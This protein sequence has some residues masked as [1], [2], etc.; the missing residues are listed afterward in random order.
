MANNEI[1]Y[2]KSFLGKSLPFPKTDKT[3]CTP[4]KNGTGYEIKYTHFSIFL[5][6]DRRL[7]Y[8]C[9]V[10]IKGEAYNAP[11][12]KGNEPWDYSD[13]VVP[14]YQIDNDFYGHD[15][16][17]FDRG[18]IVRRVD[19]CWGDFS[20]QAEQDTFHWVNC[21]P[22]HKKL[23][24]KG[25]IWYQL[26]QHVIE[27][28]VKNKLANVS[29]FAGP[30]LD[31]ADLPFKKKY[32]NSLVKVPISF[33]KVIVWKKADGNLY[34]VGFMM[35]QWE[36]IKDKLIQP[37]RVTEAVKKPLPD[38]YFENL[39]FSDHKTYQVSIPTIE[40][41]TGISFNWTN[42]NFP[43]KAKPKVVRAIPLKEVRAYSDIFAVHK[44]LSG[45]RRMAVKE[46]TIRKEIKNTPS[47]SRKSVNGI[48][49]RGDSFLLKRYQLS[50]ITL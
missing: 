31:A 2:K 39:K 26:E 3:L 18:H 9:A 40:N 14:E 23:N 25:G 45:E 46:K 30:V 43:F 17:T 32:H 24:Q 38:D 5:H 50:N 13:Q 49:S 15:E 29:V 1:G 22:Q 21:T 7:P 4:L 41:A 20:D 11:S 12:R 6:Q 27:H 19:P 35:S 48:V 37:V 8:L 44:K 36:F 42:V 16:N 28:G 47:L 33:W 34:S 10:N